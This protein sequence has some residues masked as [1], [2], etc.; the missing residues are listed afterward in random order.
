MGPI[1]F[2][3]IFFLWMGPDVDIRDL[4]DYWKPGG[5]RTDGSGIRSL[6]RERRSTV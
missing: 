3:T 6:W 4:K 1:I 5:G 2:S